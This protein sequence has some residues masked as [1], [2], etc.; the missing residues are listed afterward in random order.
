MKQ[1]SESSTSPFL[2][3]FIRDHRRVS[4]E[5]TG[6]LYN[7]TGQKKKDASTSHEKSPVKQL[8]SSKERSLEAT[9]IQVKESLLPNKG[10]SRIEEDIDSQSPLNG[11]LE[12]L[13]T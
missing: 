8:I 12:Q 7:N 9:S 5:S 13:M 1:D 11:D 4:I 3:P 2:G 6:T 10:S